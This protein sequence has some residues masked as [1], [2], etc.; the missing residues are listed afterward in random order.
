[1]TSKRPRK[2]MSITLSPD[3]ADALTTVSSDTDIPM[4]RLIERALDAYLSENYPAAASVTG[5]SQQE[6]D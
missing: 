4:A 5:G 6:N 1:M 3:V 2:R